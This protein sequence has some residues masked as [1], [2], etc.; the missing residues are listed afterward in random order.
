M[1]CDQ[2]GGEGN[3]SE[4][5]FIQEITPTTF[6]LGCCWL[7]RVLVG[8]EGASPTARGLWGYILTYGFENLAMLLGLAYVRLYVP[9]NIP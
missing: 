9:L 1:K 7:V 3:L 5:S 2:H 4:M 8:W 6:S